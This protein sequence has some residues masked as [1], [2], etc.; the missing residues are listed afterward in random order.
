MSGSFILEFPGINSP[1]LAVTHAHAGKVVE[2]QKFSCL[3]CTR[4]I[5][6]TEVVTHVLSLCEEADCGIIDVSE[7]MGADSST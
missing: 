1:I 4:S 6:A 5:K 3:V 2:S 7:R